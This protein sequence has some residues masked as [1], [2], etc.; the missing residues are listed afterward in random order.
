MKPV[1][2]E[3]FPFW[4]VKQSNFFKAFSWASASDPIRDRALKFF[5]AT[6]S[7]LDAFAVLIVVEGANQIDCAGRSSSHLNASHGREK[8][9]ILFSSLE[10]RIDFG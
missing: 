4:A 8:C 5:R 9:R 2:N 1:L 7:A 10:G 6:C 3:R